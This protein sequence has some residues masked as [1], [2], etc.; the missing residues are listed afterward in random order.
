MSEEIELLK[1]RVTRERVARLDAEQI[2]ERKAQELYEANQSLK[3][4]NSALEKQIKERTRELNTKD[5]QFRL[6]VESASDI[7][8]TTDIEGY[9]LMVNPMA[10]S[11]MD[12]ESSELIG[13]RYVDLIPDDWKEK[14]FTFYTQ[15]KESGLEK[16]YLEFPVRRKH[17]EM[18]W[19]GQSVTKNVEGD[20]VF[21]SAVARDITE[22]IEKEEELKKINSRFAILLENLVDAILVEDQERHIVLVN[23]AFCK[24]FNIPLSPSQLEGMDCS[25][26]A[27]AGKAMFV[28]EEGFVDN[29]DKLLSDKKIA[30]GE[31]L[32]T[33]DGR[34]LTRNYSPITIDGESIGNLWYYSD[35]TERKNRELIVQ[36]SEEKY[37]GVLENMELGLM[38]V[39]TEGVIQKVY[40]RFCNMFG[41]SRSELLGKNIA[42]L[43]PSFE[44]TNVDNSDLDGLKELQII[45][46]SG[47]EKWLLVS[48]A[49]FLNEHGHV[50]GSLRIHYDI[51][52]RRALE[53]ELVRAR[54]IAEKAQQA[55]KTY[56]ANMSHEIRTPL[57]AIIGMIHLVE[58]TGLNEE[59]DE[60]IQILKNSSELLLAL[61]SDVLDLAKIDSGT[62]DV[63][64]KLFDLP[65]IL[66]KLTTTFQLKATGKNLTIDHQIDP[67]I[68]KLLVGDPNLLN[69][70]LLNLLSNAEKFTE[71]GYV[72]LSAKIVDRQGDKIRIRFDV[73]DTGVGIDE[74]AIDKIFENFKQATTE[75]RDKYGGTGLGLGIVKKLADLLGGRIS[76][77]S[78][79]GKGSCFTVELPFTESDELITKTEVS[80]STAEMDLSRLNI[81]LV[82]DNPINQKYASRLLERW[83]IPYQIANNGQEAVDLFREGNYN[84]IFMDLQMPLMD[85]YEATSRIRKLERGAVIPI[86]ALTAST[87]RSKK[88]LA[89]E[90]G[91]TDFISKPFRPS[92]LLEKIKAYCNCHMAQMQESTQE[93][94]F[95]E[96]LDRTG[97]SEIYGDDAEYA[98]DIFG[99][100]IEGYHDDLAE[101]SQA[102]KSQDLEEVQRIAHKIKPGY[103]MVGMTGASKRLGEIEKCQDEDQAF[104]ILNQ[105]HIEVQTK[106]PYVLK[107]FNHL[108]ALIND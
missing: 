36:R 86:I 59:Q 82:E 5:K 103:A 11:K 101:L 33:K 17:G 14:V 25:Q 35:I 99:L 107:T 51:S 69:Q 23:N 32:H 77:E 9:F 20:E 45:T 19:L 18:L 47:E 105:I 31:E 39:D 52:D 63:Q 83:G 1:R 37:R 13:M 96:V 102:L 67:S 21:F 53:Q 104:D 43:L 10:C 100:F 92:S 50:A 29:I 6:L 42:Q 88:E 70:I 91:M 84:M 54:E 72:R 60:Y 80:K 81:L 108:T 7:I 49:P 24:M 26:F 89:L 40:D 4:L 74:G 79:P 8:F 58:E 98:A 93:H 73:E 87:M 56:L 55:E 38:E 16:S 106:M 90:T 3:R 22:R 94:L 62:M 46:K 75:V 15:M 68:K 12:Y 48:Q 28:D 64:E 57:N 78:E 44:M 30:I 85:G 61:I 76:V 66:D 41:Y 34:I 2:L 97:L 65:Y 95:S 71:S 27:D